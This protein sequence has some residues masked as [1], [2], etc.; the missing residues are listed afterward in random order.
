MRME[1][2]LKRIGDVKEANSEVIKSNSDEKAGSHNGFYTSADISS[3][4]Y[5]R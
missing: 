2:Y 3:L 1:N 5:F 4:P